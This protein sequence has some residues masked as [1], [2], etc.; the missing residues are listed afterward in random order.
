MWQKVLPDIRVHET[1]SISDA[2]TVG[3]ATRKRNPELAASLDRFARKVSKGTLLG[4][5]LFRR[6]Y[7]ETRWI[8]NPVSRKERRG[9]RGQRR[10]SCPLQDQRPRRQAA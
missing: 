4:N 10:I 8:D 3:W 7:K 6:H 1:V 9:Q 5:M 2:N